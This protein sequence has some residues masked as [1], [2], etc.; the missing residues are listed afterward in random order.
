MLRAFIGLIS[1]GHA[2]WITAVLSLIVA[3]S[4]E[5]GSWM[6]AVVVGVIV[7]GIFLCNII[8]FCVMRSAP[9]LSLK[10][11]SLRVALTLRC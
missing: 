4:L 7:V 8:G 1:L 3:L 6:A 5:F 10:R 2:G 11:V 9:P